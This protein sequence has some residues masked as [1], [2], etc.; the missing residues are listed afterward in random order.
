M[1]KGDDALSALVA[2]AT[3]GG[4]PEASAGSAPRDA[5]PIGLGADSAALDAEEIDQM[6]AMEGWEYLD[7]ASPHDGADPGNAALARTKD[8]L[9]TH[10]WP[11]MQTKAADAK[12]T[13]SVETMMEQV[14]EHGAQVP[15]DALGAA[16]SDA[17]LQRAK[18]QLARIARVEGALPEAQEAADLPAA[19]ASMRRDLETFLA[20]DGQEFDD[21]FA[22]LAS[23]PPSESLTR[24]GTPS[25]FEQLRNEIDRVRALPAGQAKQDEAARLALS[26]EQM[27]GLGDIA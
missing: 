23:R 21:D 4:H 15:D 10:A 16:P 13:P 19:P 18:E 11:G 9:M 17:D 24:N 14:L 3:G 5:V 2:T 22:E 26:V 27:L 12:D 1:G 25:F 7:L 6:Y 20:A 8:A